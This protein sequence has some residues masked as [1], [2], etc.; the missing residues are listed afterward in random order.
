MDDGEMTAKEPKKQRA[1]SSKEKVST[2]KSEPPKRG[3]RTRRAHRSRPEEE[4]NDKTEPSVEAPPILSEDG[5]VPLGVEPEKKGKKCENCEVL[6]RR[7]F[8]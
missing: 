6:I 1:D 2:A 7:L 4:T 3:G 5:V 8:N